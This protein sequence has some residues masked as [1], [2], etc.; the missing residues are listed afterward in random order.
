MS[1]PQQSQSLRCF[2]IL[3]VLLLALCGVIVGIAVSLVLINNFFLVPTQTAVAV[4]TLGA[5]MATQQ[6]QFAAETASAPPP[7]TPTA[8]PFFSPTPI[9]TFYPER[10]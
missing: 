9:P 5:G 1:R 4:Q 3:A 2:V 7:I 6:A 8:T 10:G